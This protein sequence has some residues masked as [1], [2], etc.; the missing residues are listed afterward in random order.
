MGNAVAS[1]RGQLKSVNPFNGEVLKTYDEM[2]QEEVDI[3]IGKADEAFKKWRTTSYKHRAG[4]LSCAAELLRERR[5]ELAAIMTAEMGKKIG[6]ALPEIDLCADIFDFYAT[7]GEKLLAP[8]EYDTK[9]GKGTLIHQPVGVIYGIQPWNFPYYQPSRCVAPNLIAGNVVLTK[10]ASNVPQ[11]AE[12]FDNLL[13]EAGVPE[14]VHTNLQLSARN[15]GTIIDDDRVQGVSFTGSN[16]GGATV[17][18]QAGR[19]V[20]KTV[21]ELG[22]VDPFIVLEDADMDKTVERFM[23]GKLHATGQICIAAKRIILVE[24]IAQEFL[25]R[26]TK[27][28]AELKPGDPMDEATGYGPLSTEKAAKQLET[29]VSKSVE[30]GA[31]ILVGGKRDGA[32][33][34]P[35]IM[36]DVPKGSPADCEELFGPVALIYVVKDEEEAIRV[37]NDSE[38]GLGGSVHTA[39]LERGRKAAE[40]IESGTAFVNHVSWTYASMPMG[41]VKKSGY[42]RE[43]GELGIVEFVN[44]KLIRV[45]K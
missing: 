40:R 14:G 11:C 39:D 36:T 2:T 5:E 19:N 16:K 37:A 44:Q 26:T 29:Q 13:K 18:E 15:A 3:A 38:F 12:A 9:E 22:G 27:L 41:G 21:M 23:F 32:F 43:L 42:G 10:H 1:E 17:A 35:T 31:K 24:S 34:E 33:F 25:D 7:E 28:F 20:K 30:A 6:D 4:I 8:K 45:F